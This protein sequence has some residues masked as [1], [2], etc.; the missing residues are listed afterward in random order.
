MTNRQTVRA[1]LEQLDGVSDVRTL[2][3]SG[4]VVL[5]STTPVAALQDSIEAALPT[6]FALDTELLRVLV[7]TSARYRAIVA[8]APPGFGEQPDTVHSDA[9]FLMGIRAASAMAVF[10]PREGVDR[11]WPGT[12]VIFSQRLSAERTRSRLSRIVGTTAYQS[13]TIRNWNTV[14]RLLAIVDEYDEPSGD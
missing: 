2:I 12:G 9:I 8:Q 11:V 10:D 6:R 14:Q 4:N 7:L 3:A 1:C 13:M 5:R